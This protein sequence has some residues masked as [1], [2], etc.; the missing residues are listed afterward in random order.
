M[1]LDAL[2]FFSLSIIDKEI[3]VQGLTAFEILTFEWGTMSSPPGSGAMPTL[4][5]LLELLIRINSIAAASH[6]TQ[7]MLKR[8]QG[9]FKKISSTN[10]WSI[11]PQFLF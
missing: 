7:N 2:R 8:T 11:F 3:S 10:N 4:R 6:I 5:F 1:L 9:H